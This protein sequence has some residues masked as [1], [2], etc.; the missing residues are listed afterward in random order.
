MPPNAAR[1]ASRPV[2][3]APEKRYRRAPKRP[4]KWAKPTP[5]TP[6]PRP[7]PS[8]VRKSSTPDGPRPHLRPG[9]RRRSGRARVRAGTAPVPG[10]LGA[11]SPVRRRCPRSGGR[12][13]LPD[14]RETAEDRRRRVPA[15]GPV[16]TVGSPRPARPARKSAPE[17]RDVPGG[18]FSPRRAARGRDVPAPGARRS[19]AS[20]ARGRRDVLAARSPISPVSPSR[21]P[22]ARPISGARENFRRQGANARDAKKTSEAPKQPPRIERIG[23]DARAAIRRFSTVYGDPRTFAEDERATQLRTA[24]RLTAEP[25]PEGAART[26]RPRGP[27]PPRGSVQAFPRIG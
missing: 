10:L 27:A 18:P 1:S 17:G 26:A 16:S 23:E 25:G 14:G 19:T 24:P 6:D 9:P 3:P 13:P 22:T 8:P 21:P 20:T 12:E 7:P 4:G 2:L 5:G 15:A 11:A